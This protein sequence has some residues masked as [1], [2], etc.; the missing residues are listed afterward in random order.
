M[1][2]PKKFFNKSK[3][4]FKKSLRKFGYRKKPTV[5]IKKEIKR[6]I[7]RA[8]ETKKSYLEPTSANFN[9]QTS[10]NFGVL[11]SIT[12]ANAY[13]LMPTINLGTDSQ[14]R[15]GNTIKAKGLYVKGHIY[16]NWQNIT[17]S[18]ASFQ[19]MYVR[20][21]CISDK[22]NPVDSI[23]YSNFATS[24]QN[25]LQKGAFSTNFLFSDQASLYRP[26]NSD[27]F[28]VHYDK[29]IKLGAYSALT[30]TA[31]VDQIY[32]LKQ[33]KFKVPMKQLLKYDDTNNRPTNCSMPLLLIGYCPGDNFKVSTTTAPFVNASYYS[34]FYYQDG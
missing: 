2:T 26:V 19:T 34:D 33:F 8:V 10:N 3:K 5:S 22:Q 23:A 15:I 13:Q 31:N 17:A 25:L 18:S 27:R 9:T 29:V 14:S 7:S 1:K 16:A 20:I 12:Q 11:P 21:L 4:T 6:Q 32:G 24:Y 30:S 28:T